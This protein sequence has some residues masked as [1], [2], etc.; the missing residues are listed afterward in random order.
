[1]RASVRRDHSAY[2]Y[3]PR[4]HFLIALFTPLPS[5]IT[6]T[7]DVVF[8][9]PKKGQPMSIAIVIILVLAAIGGGI[10]LWMKRQRKNLLSKKIKLAESS[11]LLDPSKPSVLDSVVSPVSTSSTSSS[12]GERPQI[13]ASSE[14]TSTGGERLHPDG[15]IDASAAAT[16]AAEPEGDKKYIAKFRQQAPT[17]KEL[18]AKLMIA[19]ELST[20]AQYAEER[21]W[22]LVRD[23]RHMVYCGIDCRFIPDTTSASTFV[24]D[25]NIH[26]A[27]QLSNYKNWFELSAKVALAAEAA[28]TAFEELRQ[29]LKPFDRANSSYLPVDLQVLCESAHAVLAASRESIEK[30]LKKAQETLVKVEKEELEGQPLKRPKIEK[31][32]MGDE[33][34][35]AEGAHKDDESDTN[36]ARAALKQ[37]M[38]EAI[39]ESAKCSVSASAVDDIFEKLET[40]GKRSFTFPKKPIPEEIVRFLTEVELWSKEKL[41]TERQ[42]APLIAGANQG[43]KDLKEAVKALKRSRGRTVPVLTDANRIIDEGLILAANRVVKDLEEAIDSA[44]KELA[45]STDKQPKASTPTPTAREEEEATI[46][47]L[48]ADART[49]SFALAQ[50]SVAWTKLSHIQQQQP[51]VSATPPHVDRSDAFDKYLERY[52]RF[53]ERLSGQRQEFAKWE[54]AMELI[55][56]AYEAR[57][58]KVSETSTALGTKMAE[59]QK[60]LTAKTADELLVVGDMVAK[61][62]QLIGR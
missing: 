44:V 33:N 15:T 18:A 26:F 31:L 49:V 8:L 41:D 35:F 54:A 51:A 22:R 24:T 5:S 9:N 25:T 61:I 11:K 60:T 7:A 14:D 50:R 46:K 21:A 20:E 12:A 30:K 36:E 38:V 3:R 16:A 2:R 57:K 28:S 37:A 19:W 39:E 13:N 45:E 27:G 1:M 48:R 56:M 43:I 34:T 55:Q 52:Q 58:A 62:V 40:I 6:R 32:F 53:Q 23:S 10:Y 42:V 59:V 29:A 17:I 47:L 4:W